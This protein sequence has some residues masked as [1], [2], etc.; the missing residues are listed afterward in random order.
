MTARRWGFVIA[1]CCSQR[2]TVIQ[3]GM[4]EMSF[5]RLSCSSV[6][7]LLLACSACALVPALALGATA[8]DKTQFSVVAGSLAFSTTPAMP[9]LTGVTING[10]A[11]T[12]NTTMTNFGVVDATGSGAGWNTTV[13]GQSGT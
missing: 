3:R 10:A 11:Q 7:V 9:T 12:T 8:E 1:I 2:R 4:R 5:R 13:A 6:I